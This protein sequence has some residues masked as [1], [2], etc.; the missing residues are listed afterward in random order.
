MTAPS[1]AAL[2]ALPLTLVQLQG[3]V[4]PI[5]AAYLKAGFQSNIVGFMP[6]GNSSYHG[7]ATELNRRMS[8]NLQF[9]GAYTW[10]HAID[11][12]TAAVFSTLI[13]P[14]RVQNFQ[15]L[16]SERSSSALDRR[17]R[18]SLSWIYDIAAYK[19]S[20]NWAAKNL[21]GNWTYTGTYV[22]ESPQYAVVQSGLDSNLNGDAAGDRAI[23][24]QAGDMTKGSGVTALKNSAGGTVAY[25]A[26][27]PNAR[28]IVAGAGA[29]ANG[30]RMTLPLRGIRNFD[31]TLAKNFN[32]TEHKR[33]QFR[34][35]F[36]NAFN[37]SQFTPGSINTVQPISRT[38]TRN[39]LIP[40]NANFNN[41]E[42]AFGNNPRLIQLAVK[43]L[44]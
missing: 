12:G 40:S 23:V 25:L 24:N 18:L 8:R 27:N 17:H 7:L 13:A 35:D 19:N 10:S 41:P 26:N 1:Q 14:R 16:R 33:I 15:D 4:D 30:G 11:D 34:A 6:I 42:T 5:R 43:Y 20:H 21:I 29:Y 3:Q 2:N 36:Y 28:Y 39:Y 37:H 32:V 44:F 38:D 9:K 22:F 31:M